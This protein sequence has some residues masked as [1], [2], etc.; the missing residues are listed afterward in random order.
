MA[1]AAP[2]TQGTHH[3]LAK[4]AEGQAHEESI[5]DGNHQAQRLQLKRQRR[6]AGCS[7]WAAGM[8]DRSLESW[9]GFEQ[10][11]CSLTSPLRCQRLQCRPQ[12]AG[13]L[14][15]ALTC[16]ASPHHVDYLRHLDQGAAQQDAITQAL[17]WRQNAEW[18]EGNAV[19]R[20]RQAS[21]PTLRWCH[22]I[23][24]GARSSVSHFTTV[25]QWSF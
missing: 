23:N 21:P 25:V 13:T 19:S 1:G 20:R 17:H 18:A 14:R 22:L 4:G 2:C 24:F 7:A 9:R 12:G 10:Q 16:T 6:Q 3:C 11:V 15:R 8:H 5:G